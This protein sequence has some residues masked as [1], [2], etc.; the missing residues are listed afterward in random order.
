MYSTCTSVSCGGKGK[1]G[2]AETQ[3]EPWLLFKKGPALPEEKLELLTRILQSSQS[4]SKV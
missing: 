1:D 4:H 2:D 3:R